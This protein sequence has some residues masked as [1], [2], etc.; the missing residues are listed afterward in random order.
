[1]RRA[2]AENA[3]VISTTPV[4]VTVRVIRDG[5]RTDNCALGVPRSQTWRGLIYLFFGYKRIVFSI[6]LHA[7]THRVHP[8]LDLA[9]LRM[10]FLDEVMFELGEVLDAFALRAKLIQKGHS[11][12]L[13]IRYIHQN[14]QPSKGFQSKSAR[15]R[16]R[17][18]PSHI[19]SIIAGTIRDGP[20]PGYGA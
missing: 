9:D 18:Y 5:R 1:M 13:K 12:C 7:A 16:S 14:K 15:K 8:L 3:A 11:V 17:F 20:V 10:H 2:N 6:V 4:R 19:L